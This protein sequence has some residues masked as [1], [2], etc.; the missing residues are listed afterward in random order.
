MRKLA[1]WAM[2]TMLV[3]GAALPAAAQ[4]PRLPSKLPGQDKV[5]SI[6][7]KM[8][9]YT[10]KVNQL[11][12]IR[13]PWSTDDEEQIGAASAAKVIHVFGLYTENPAM[14]KYVNLVGNVVAKQ[15]ARSD[16]QYHFAILDAEVMNAMALPGGFIFVTRGALINMKSE[17]ELAG[18]LAH[19]VAHVDGRHL[20]NEIK[21]KNTNQFLVKT[22]QE[23]GQKLTSDQLM[24]A[25]IQR[26]GDLA[27]EAVL[28]KSYS[29]G[30]EAAADRKGMDFAAKAGYAPSG[31]RDFLQ[32]LAAASG[33]PQ[34]T[35]KTSSWG[36][37]HPPLSDRV[38][39]LTKQASN[40]PAGGQTLADRF[41]KNVNDV[42][43]GNL[44]PAPPPA[45]NKGGKGAPAGAASQLAP[46]ASAP[47]EYDGVVRNGVVVLRGPKKPK[48]GT[49][50]KVIPQ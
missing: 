39:N 19:E 50:V 35:V 45:P 41:T 4:F 37:T 42:A 25:L 38:A 29:V 23:E 49:K 16:T 40:Y 22:G 10:N 32:T 6:Q 15:G 13:K 47:T 21:N 9:P 3:L 33:D 31:L 34:Y 36:Q 48:E 20:E 27:A 1:T 44:P 8:K 17:A 2:A 11:T 46:A 28:T 24:S 26:V 43:F 14:T 7:A 18:V 12:D 30:D 5:E